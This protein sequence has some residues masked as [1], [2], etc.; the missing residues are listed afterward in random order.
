MID[1]DEEVKEYDGGIGY[2]SNP[3][4]ISK[5]PYQYAPNMTE[6]SYNKLILQGCSNFNRW[7]SID[8]DQGSLMISFVV[9][10]G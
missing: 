5:I 8:R 7:V 10:P 2:G 6:S 3:S 1:I 9:S 4:L